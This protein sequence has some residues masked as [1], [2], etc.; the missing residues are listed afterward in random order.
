MRWSSELLIKLQAYFKYANY[1]FF[2]KPTKT[3]FWY[4]IVIPA[5]DRNLVIMSIVF[6]FAIKEGIE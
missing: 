2:Q 1:D 6:L 5:S 4:Q 3:N